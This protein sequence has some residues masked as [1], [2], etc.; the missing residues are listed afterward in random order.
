MTSLGF[1]PGYV[2][3]EACLP[4]SGSDYKLLNTFEFI[5]AVS[6]TVLDKINAAY[7][8]KPLIFTLATFKE[9]LFSHH[10]AVNINC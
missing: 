3:A 5:K 7:Y 8:D 1:Y 4:P 2:S 9:K 6:D 10:R